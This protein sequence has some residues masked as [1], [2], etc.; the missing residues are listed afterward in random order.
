MCMIER[1]VLCVMIVMEWAARGAWDVWIRRRLAVEAHCCLVRLRVKRVMSFPCRFT[2]MEITYLRERRRRSRRVSRYPL[3][4]SL[5]CCCWH[6]R[7]W[8]ASVPLRR[9]P[10]RRFFGLSR[11][12]FNRPRVDLSESGCASTRL[13]LAR[14]PSAHGMLRTRRHLLRGNLNAKAPLM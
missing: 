7:G 11:V 8:I 13:K 5:C 3:A 14:L 12:Q 2:W 10:L 4:R 9:A 6:R 1:R